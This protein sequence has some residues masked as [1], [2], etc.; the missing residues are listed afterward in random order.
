M[1]NPNKSTLKETNIM[2]NG[3]RNFT[4]TKAT[5]RLSWEEAEAQQTAKR[6]GE[7][8]KA[9][10]GSKRNSWEETNEDA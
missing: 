9:Q 8:R 10:R 1:I 4:K 2:T 5:K 7:D 3:I 6:K